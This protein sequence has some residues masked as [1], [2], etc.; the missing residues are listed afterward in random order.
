LFTATFVES[1]LVHG[2][3][4]GGHRVIFLRPWEYKAYT[5]PWRLFTPFLITGPK[6]EFLMDLY[7]CTCA[8]PL[9]LIVLKAIANPPPSVYL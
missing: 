3:L 2:G 6:F 7:F 5:E 1:A 4:L 8:E 9:L